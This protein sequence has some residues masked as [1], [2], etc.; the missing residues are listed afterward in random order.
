MPDLHLDMPS[1]YI[2]YPLFWDRSR[3]LVLY[4]GADSGKSV[5]AAQKIIFRCLTEKNHRFLLL[6]KVQRTIKNSQFQAIKEM[7]YLH[8]LEK[9]F[10]FIPSSLEIHAI[11]NNVIL[12]AG[13]DDPEKLK[14]IHGITGIWI[15]EPTELAEQDFEEANRRLRG[16]RPYYKQIIFSFNPID[17]GHWLFHEFFLDSPPVSHGTIKTTRGDLKLSITHSTYTD[18]RW[19]DPD[20]IRIYENYAG[21]F[22]SIYARGIWGGK[23][24]PDQVISHTD[25]AN[26]Y[27]TEPI[28]GPPK[29]LGVDVA[30]YGNDKTVLL[31]LDGNIVAKI[32]AYDQTSTVQTATY[33]KI[34]MIQEGIPANLVGID[35]IGI[36]SGVIDQLRAEGLNVV[37]I[38]AGAVPVIGAIDDP[39]FRSEGFFNLRSQMYWNARLLFEKKKIHFP[40]KTREIKLLIGDLSTVRYSITGDKKIRVESKDDIKSRIGRSPDYGD[41]FLNAAF[42]DKLSTMPTLNLDLM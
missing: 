41:A 23:T 33:T 22:K 8:G 13:I 19:T 37:G 35:Q 28:E 31:T 5:F 11:N 30:R 6:R 42:V 29:K 12:G 34:E 20:N 25:L 32:K 15:E 14:S 10:R 26:A 7:V 27:I 16:I 9:A 36:G 1:N 17:Q 3:Y 39:S 18:N 38:V 24:E 4:G 40:E 2:Y 21:V